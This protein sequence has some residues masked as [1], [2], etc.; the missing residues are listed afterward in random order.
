MTTIERT[1]LCS[2][3]KKA[4]GI[5]ICQGCRRHFCYRHVAEHRQEL[6]LELDEL[7]NNHDQLQQTISEQTV[8]PNSHP[9]IKELEQWDQ[10]P[11]EDVRQQLLTML[12]EH[13]T[14]IANN[15]TCITNE[16]KQ[17][18]YDDDFM[19]TDL[20]QWREKLDQLKTNLDAVHTLDSRPKNN[21][22]ELIENDASTEIF[23]QTNGDVQIEGDGKI[24]VHGPTS[25]LVAV[26]CRGEYSLGQHRFRFRIERTSNGV[27]FIYGI[28]S[29]STPMSLIINRIVP[30]GNN[31][32]ETSPFIYT[33]LNKDVICSFTGENYGFQGNGTYEVVIDCSHWKVCLTN[34]QI[35]ATKNLYVNLNK[36]PFPWQFFVVINYVNDRVCL[37]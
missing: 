34:E 11:S 15:L 14:E 16:L 9:F 25:G 29:K 22:F 20:K 3:C 30:N 6:N 33:S 37:C 2:T 10:Q 31:G 36:F 8:Q 24:A 28:V 19:E 17:A 7:A 12:A 32:S 18:R 26:R 27:G 23:Y 35:E 1:T 21:H 5:L 13:R 4:S